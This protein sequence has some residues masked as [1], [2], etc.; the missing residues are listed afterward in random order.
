MAKSPRASQ[1]GPT[2][3]E[4]AMVIN[5]ATGLLEHDDGQFADADKANLRLM[6]ELADKARSARVASDDDDSPAGDE[7][8]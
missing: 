5:P 1:P 3:D 6:Q 2:Q 4:R 7:P 8:A